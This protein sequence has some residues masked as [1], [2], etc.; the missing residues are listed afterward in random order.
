MDYRDLNKASPNDDFHLPYIDVLV[1]NSTKK[2][3]MYSFMDGFSRYNQIKMAEEDKEKTTLAIPLGTF[4][5]K[6]MPF[7]LKNVK[8]T[9]QK[10][11][12]TLFHDMMHQEV[13]VH[14]HDMQNR[15]KKKII[16]KF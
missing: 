10:E 4:Y 2:N 9:Y 12:V 6:V 15:R 3:V 5:Y 7:K 14:V 16:C 13:E 11:M 1:D 8:A